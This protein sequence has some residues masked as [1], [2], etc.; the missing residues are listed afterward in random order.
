MTIYHGLLNPIHNYLV[1]FCLFF[2]VITVIN[3]LSSNQLFLMVIAFT[4][5]IV[6]KQSNVHSLLIHPVIK[7]FNKHSYSKASLPRDP[8]DFAILDFYLYTRF[9]RHWLEP[10]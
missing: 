3:L 5:F 7:I 2:L 9:Y 6:N 8:S 1:D 4:K 10:E